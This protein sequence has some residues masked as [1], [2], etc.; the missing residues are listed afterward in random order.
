MNSVPLHSLSKRK[1]IHTTIGEMVEWSITTVLKTVVPRGTGGSNPSL[2]AETPCSSAFPKDG[3]ENGHENAGFRCEIRRSLFYNNTQRVSEIKTRRITSNVNAGNNI[4][5]HVWHF[6][7]MSFHLQRYTFL[8]VPAQF[9]QEIVQP[10][11][12]KRPFPPCRRQKNG[13]QDGHHD[14]GDVTPSFRVLRRFVVCDGHRMPVGFGGRTHGGRIFPFGDAV[15]FDLVTGCRFP[16]M[17]DVAGCVNRAILA[18]GDIVSDAAGRVK[19]DF[20]DDGVAGFRHCR[21]G[22]HLG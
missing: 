4:V 6:A 22:V 5:P 13:N 1:L 20:G 17:P 9:L 15:A 14:D 19:D 21:V 7:T 16:Y 10:S 18:D 3:H 11:A 8:I 2:S 12:Q